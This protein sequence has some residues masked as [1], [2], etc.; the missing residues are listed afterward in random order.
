VQWHPEFHISP[1]DVKLFEA[2]IAAAKK[3]ASV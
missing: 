2:F 3:R 1:A